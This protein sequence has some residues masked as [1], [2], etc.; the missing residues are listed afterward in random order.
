MS[1]ATQDHTYQVSPVGLWQH[2][3]RLEWSQLPASV[4]TV[5]QQSV[6]DWFACTIAGA[7]E[8]L[9]QLLRAEYA[10]QVGA[11]SVVGSRLKVDPKSAALLNGAASHALDYDDTNLIMGGHSTVPVLPAVL[12]LGESLQVTGTQLLAS[13][14]VGVEIE[15]LLGRAIGAEHYAKGW[16]V[17]STLGVFGA[18]AGAAHLLGLSEEQFGHAMGL[19]ASQASGLKANFGTMTKP[20]HAGHAAERGLLSARLAARGFTANPNA[21][22]A[23]QG[24]LQ[25]AGSGQ[26]QHKRLQTFGDSWTTT[27]TLFKYHAACYFTHAAIESSLSLRASTDIDQ[28]A[29]ITLTVHPSLL[30]VCAIAQPQTGLEGKFSLAG[31]TAMALLGIDTSSPSSFVDTTMQRADV[32]ALAAKV[33]LETDRGLAQTQT[34]VA[35]LGRDQSR[36]VADFDSGVPATDLQ[37]QQGKIERKFSALVD[38][39]APASPTA[40]AVN[41]VVDLDNIQALFR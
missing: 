33:Q 10:E 37:A 35:I 14:V 21:F 18:A 32:Q 22:T 5:A 40:A 25:A 31:T 41:A 26:L 1:T 27:H 16:H 7:N 17:T 29:D 12:A 6:L 28:I 3:G 20:F 38:S 15:G 11:A 8:P 34:R 24:L 9:S 4:Q 39:A 30:D 13:F 36:Q 2:Y 23:Q 19:A